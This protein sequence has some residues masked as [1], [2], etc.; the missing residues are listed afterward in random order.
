MARLQIQT[1]HSDLCYV[2]SNLSTLNCIFAKAD[3]D[4]EIVKL[5]SIFWS[6]IGTNPN[7]LEESSMLFLFSD[8]F[9]Q[10][11]ISILPKFT[12]PSS[13]HYCASVSYANSETR[14]TRMSSYIVQRDI[15]N[16]FRSY[17]RF[18]WFSFCSFG[19]RWPSN[20]S[21]HPPGLGHL[22]PKICC[23]QSTLW[24]WRSWFNWA[25]RPSKTL[26]NSTSFCRIWGR[27]IDKT[28]TGVGGMAFLHDYLFNYSAVLFLQHVSN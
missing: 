25:D 18:F 4:H 9:I 14:R 7:I 20:L 26:D 10:P 21:K 15:G 28:F 16:F 8:L 22:W 13:F 1:N 19:S 17:L 23:P 3:I 2:L 5:N 11:N 6:F 24:F 12:A 27:L